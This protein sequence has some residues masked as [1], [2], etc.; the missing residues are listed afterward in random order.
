MTTLNALSDYLRV[1]AV[2]VDEHELVRRLRLAEGVK[3][4]P[5][6]DTAGKTTIGIGRNL[7]DVGLRFGPL[8]NEMQ[9]LLENDILHCLQTAIHKIPSFRSHPAHVQHILVEMLFVLGL[10][11]FQGFVRFLDALHI[12]NYTHAAQEL[13]NSKWFQEYPE[14]VRPLV[15]S[16]QRGF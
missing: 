10:G 13:Q 7:T 8:H 6:L 2:N 16:L 3:T 15:E 14:R 4:F 5:Y 11:K 1:L 9:I 12:F